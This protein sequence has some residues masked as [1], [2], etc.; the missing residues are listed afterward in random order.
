M[1]KIKKIMILTLVMLTLGTAS[2]GVLT[3]QAAIDN[4]SSWY[5][6]IWQYG[7]MGGRNFSHYNVTDTRRIGATASVTNGA[8]GIQSARSDYNWARASVNDVW[9]ARS[10]AY[11]GYY[12][13]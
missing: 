12:W 2:E 11:W 3:A 6:D 4:P 10:Q 9:Y 7:T 13:F 8:G 5:L 1:S